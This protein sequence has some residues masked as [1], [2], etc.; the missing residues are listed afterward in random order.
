MY[1]PGRRRGAWGGW[2]CVIVVVWWEG[3]ARGVIVMGRRGQS[4]APESLVHAA[5]PAETPHKKERKER[6]SRR[7][8]DAKRLV[9]VWRAITAHTRSRR[10]VHPF[11]PEAS[12]ESRGHAY[13]WSQREGLYHC[14]SGLEVATWKQSTRPCTVST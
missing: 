9:A 4:R 10:G 13:M 12:R 14:E 5:P 11:V 1:L 7:A 3:R 2:W 6:Q 8:A